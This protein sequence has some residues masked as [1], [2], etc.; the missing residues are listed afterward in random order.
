ML[1]GHAYSFYGKL[2]AA[3][4][5]EVLEVWTKEVDYENIV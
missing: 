3:H 1:S 2:A 4:V 5:K